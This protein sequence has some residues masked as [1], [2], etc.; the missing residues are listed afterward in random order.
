MSDLEN[1]EKRFFDDDQDEEEEEMGEDV[2][3]PSDSDDE[4]E[5]E[6]EDEEEARKIAEGFIVDDEEEEDSGSDQAVTSKRKKRKKVHQVTEDDSDS[7]DE[8]DLALLEENMGIK[9][10]RNEGPQLKR[11]KRGRQEARSQRS[12]TD[13]KNFFSDEEA[14]E[15]ADRDTYTRRDKRDRAREEEFTSRNRY[16]REYDDMNDFIADDVEDDLEDVVRSGRKSDEARYEEK[17]ARESKESRRELL[18]MLPADMD[19]DALDDMYD[20]F[21]DGGDYEY[22][23]FSHQELDQD[24]YNEQ[25]REPQLK[26]VFEPSELQERMLTEEDEDIRLRDIPERMQMRYQG[27]NR[28]FTPATE[29]QVEAES[30]WISKTMAA[31]EGKEQASEE[32]SNAIKYIVKFF[33]QEFLEVPYIVYHRRDYFTDIDKQTGRTR[34]IL[35]TDDLW[36]IYDYDFKYFSFADRK[37]TFHVYVNKLGIEDEYITEMEKKSDKIEEIADLI[38]YVNLKYAQDISRS[39]K[40]SKGPK[41]PVNRSLYNMSMNSKVKDFVSHFGIAPKEFGANY[42]DGTRRHYPEDTLTGP[43]DDASNFVDGTFVDSE[44]VLKAAKAVLAQEIAFDPQV[45]KA[46]RRDW[47]TRSCVSVKPTDKGNRIIDEFHPMH[48]FKYLL[49]KPVNKFT[50][51]QFLHILKAETDGLLTIDITLRGFDRWFAKFSELYMSDGYSDSAQAWNNQRSSILKQA[52]D[53]YLNPLMSKSIREKLRVEAQDHICLT[54][55]KNLE[56]K[57]DV[58]PYRTQYVD[59][60]SLPRV[61]TISWGNGDQ[62]DSVMVVFVNQYGRLADQLRLPNLKDDTSRQQ[63]MDLISHRKPDV[64]G[65][66]GFNIQ[67]RRLLDT[68]QTLVNELKEQT[69]N[70]R[71]SRHDR[72][73]AQVTIVNDE[74]ARLYQGSKRATEEFKELPPLMRYCISLARRLQNPVMEYVAL[75]R[76]LLQIRHHPLQALVPEDMILPYL[77]RALLNVVNSIGIDINA[78]LKDTYIASALPYICGFGPRKAQHTLQ[79]IEATGGELE[80][81]SALVLRRLT[82]MAIFMNCAS[83]LRIVD[84]DG[85]DILDDTR[86]HPQ[87]YELARKMAA[88][89][90]EIDEDDM[91]DFDAKKAVVAK[92]IRSHSDKL[93]DLI[94]EDYAVV[95]REQ[96]D[97]PKR[98]ILEHIKLELQGPYRDRRQEYK[99]YT[100]NQIF[101]MI[102]GETDDTLKEGYIVPVIVTKIRGKWANCRLDSGIDGAISIENASDRRLM[103]IDE[104]LNVGQTLDAKVLRIDRERYHVDLSCKESDL[105]HGDVSLRKQPDDEFYSREEEEKLRKQQ[106]STRKKVAKT[107]RMIKHPLFHQLNHREAEEYL[108]FRQRG[109]LVIRPSSKGNDHIAITWKVADGVYQHVDVLELEKENDYALGNKLQIGDQTFEDL[110]ELIV[111]YVEA[112]AKKVDELMAHHKYKAGGLSKLYDFLTSATMANAKM[113]AYGFCMDEKAG[114]FDLAFKLNAKASPTRWLVKVLPN[115]YRLQNTSYP[116]VTDLINGFKRIQLSKNN[117]KQQ[118]Q[119]QQQRPPQGR[120]SRGGPPPPMHAA[121]P[122]GY[123]PHMGPPPPMRH[124]YP[125]YPGGRWNY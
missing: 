86:I 43:E 52:L 62:K 21:G 59:E 31:A 82:P 49:E 83:F 17:H 55:W 123:P 101:S 42:L 110:D 107:S 96:Y 117:Q 14:E 35:T 119:Q 67:T 77:E 33:T 73:H 102:S 8:E 114:Y 6:D 16:R 87:D 23:M 61:M 111:T 115:G 64:I 93:N 50:D 108:E 68:V 94:L 60:D 105:V 72:I 121:P 4:E 65:V 41:R 79:R 90:L 7:L 39:Q 97:A 109:D 118:Q 20:I 91:D 66:A 38:D 45:R 57:V 40:Y 80:S 63:L 19:Q 95:L 22:A 71:S 112:I 44:K 85:A 106:S 24:N 37:R 53:E 30:Q 5:E 116:N 76:D 36:K 103:S 75:G 122:M 29:E 51:G 34:E 74:V 120:S 1:E 125:A 54:A 15:A 9:L 48:P 2:N 10:A 70:S 84:L 12:D 26:D 81:R 98:Q 13:M 104:V 99:K 92:V 58:K 124:Q 32:K 28:N 46:V 56:E 18:E 25:Q 89:A 11:L 27:L 88:D 3:R 47:E 100:T 113:S 78:A 69:A